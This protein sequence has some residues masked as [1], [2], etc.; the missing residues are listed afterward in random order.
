VYD[1]NGPSGPPLQNLLHLNNVH[2]EQ[3]GLYLSGM[4]TRALLR[5]AGS[6]RLAVHC[7]LPE[8]VHNARPFRDGVLFNDT[9]ADHVRFVS[10][11]G[12]QSAFRTPHFDPAEL[13]FA[14]VN[15]AKVARQG[16]GRGLCP[17]DLRRIA[18]G[19]SPS[20]VSIYDLEQRSR[21]GSVTLTMD[22]RNAI[23][24]L[25]VWPYD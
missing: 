22:I 23:H 14:G 5:F 24:G 12:E 1:P 19:S 18:A 25:E 15:D 21:L 13:E 16:F 10:R 3:S 11:S 6:E 7:S 4:R 20:T 9:A 2:A 17:L 8:G